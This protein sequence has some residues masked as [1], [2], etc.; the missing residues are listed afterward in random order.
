[1][2]RALQANTTNIGNITQ[3]VRWLA[4]EK[5]NSKK[6]QTEIAAAVSAAQQAPKKDEGKKD[7][8]DDDYV[9]YTIQCEIFREHLNFPLSSFGVEKEYGNIIKA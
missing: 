4:P 1:Y 9:P 5:M 8:K 2:S 3:I 7:R 6:I